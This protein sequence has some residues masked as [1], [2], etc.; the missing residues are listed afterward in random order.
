M[1]WVKVYMIQVSTPR[2]SM[3][4]GWWVWGGLEVPVLQSEREELCG[5]NYL[6]PLRRH[7]IVP[8]VP[9][10]GATSTVFHHAVQFQPVWLFFVGR[11]VLGALSLSLL[12]F[13]VCLLKVFVANRSER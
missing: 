5:P 7:G 2:R 3:K 11:L 10:D 1:A 9:T 8:R 4:R 12:V 13:C 6:G